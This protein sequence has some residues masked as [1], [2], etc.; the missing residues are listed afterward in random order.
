MIAIIGI[1]AAIIIPTV[2]KVRDSA[3]QA[4]CASN[5]RQI[6]AALFL[7][8]ADNKNTL[9]AVATE[10][11]PTNQKS[12]W[13]WKIWSY[14][15]YPEN[16]FRFDAGSPPMNDLSVRSGAVGDN[17]FNC[18]STRVA[19]TR[20]PTVTQAVNPNLF[21]YG[22]NS[23]PHGWTSA[24]AWTLSIPMRLITQPSRGAMVTETSFC[25]G[26]AEGYLNLYGLIP[27]GGGSNVLFYDGHVEYRKAADIP[28]DRSHTFWRGR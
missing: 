21:S 22:L 12:T 8:A 2:G 16:A 4:S 19:Q 26:D 25:L 17:V 13:G 6:G 20:F 5:L 28:T 14:A 27:H 10:W 9:P 1:L 23:S 18:P 3:R 11:A 24:S 7:Y 15:G